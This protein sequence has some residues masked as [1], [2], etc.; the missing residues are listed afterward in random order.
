MRPDKTDSG[1]ASGIIN[2]SISISAECVDHPWMIHTINLS[3][4][5]FYHYHPPAH[6]GSCRSQISPSIKPGDVQIASHKDTKLWDHYCQ[7][8]YPNYMK[9]NYD[10]I[11][12]RISSVINNLSISASVY[13]PPANEGIILVTKQYHF[14]ARF[15]EKFEFEI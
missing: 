3:A 10:N 5:I 1:I 4:L 2:S 13:P 6:H 7:I 14:F 12:S 15:N 11:G 9:Q 8:L